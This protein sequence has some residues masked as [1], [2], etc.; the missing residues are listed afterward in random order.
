[1]AAS[2][3]RRTRLYTGRP[4]GSSPRQHCCPQRSTDLG[5][6]RAGPGQAISVLPDRLDLD[7]NLELVPNQQAAALQRSIPGQPEVLA[8]DGRLAREAGPLLT[9]GV[10]ASPVEG[11]RQRYLACDSVGRELS[12]DAQLVRGAPLDPVLVKMILG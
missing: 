5:P 11:C 3:L 12:D 6:A 8:V 2:V 9:R 4:G 10:L 1:M 7:P